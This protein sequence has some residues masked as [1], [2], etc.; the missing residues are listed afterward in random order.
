[1]GFSKGISGNP[2]GRP[3]G[4]KNT[5]TIDAFKTA[6]RRIEKQDKINILEHFIRRSLVSE[7]VLVALINKLLPNAD[8][9]A[10]SEWDKELVKHDIQFF[11]YN[12]LT[13]EKIKSFRKYLV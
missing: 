3:K 4:S 12:D 10:P 6:I 9:N 7:K 13:E 5:F 1:M 11:F 8:N 2:K